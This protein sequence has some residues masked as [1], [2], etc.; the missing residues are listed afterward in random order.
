M[1]SEIR[2]RWVVL[3]IPGF[4]LGVTPSLQAQ[5]ALEWRPATQT[6][7]VGE[8]VEVGLYA[9][10][11]DTT[12]Y[13]AQTETILGWDPAA[14]LLLGID[15]R[16]TVGGEL[17]ADGEQCG[18]TLPDCPAGEACEDYN[19]DMRCTV[20]GAPQP[21]G[22]P[23]GSAWP[24]CPSGE[25]CLLYRDAWDWYSSWFPDDSAGDGLNY[26]GTGL[27]DN[28]GDA[29]HVAQVSISEPAAPIAADGTL[30]IAFRFQAVLPGVTEL[31]LVPEMGQYS[32]TLVWLDGTGPVPP[33]LGDP[34]AVVVTGGVPIPAV[35]AWGVVTTAL[36]LL[37]AGS[38][39]F[40]RRRL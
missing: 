10:S 12:E 23:C 18:P 36:M 31:A 9:I 20:E 24:D 2:W 32:Q 7:A 27:P 29:Y 28:D 6:R 35:S 1:I 38:M 30:I 13:V 11:A 19:I 39:A 34:A 33:A 26:P 14:L 4:C 5:V 8:T 21:D 15:K 3:S 40:R 37:A 25:S 17:D 16:C 22:G